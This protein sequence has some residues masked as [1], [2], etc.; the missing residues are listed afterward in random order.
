MGADKFRLK[1][2]K[3]KFCVIAVSIIP[4]PGERKEREL[5]FRRLGEWISSD[6]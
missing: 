4:F 6:T 5:R 3:L 2:S 1:T